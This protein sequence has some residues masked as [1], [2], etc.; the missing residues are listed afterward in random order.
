MASALFGKVEVSLFVA[1]AVLG[2]IWKHSRSAKCCVFPYEMLA[3]S[4]KNNLGCAAG[5]RLT[6]SCSDHARF[7]LFS[8]KLCEIAPLIFNDVAWVT[9]INLENHFRGR[10]KHKFW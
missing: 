8:A 1:S 2:E 7:Q 5:C 3:A 9:Q 10:G 4:A 6:G